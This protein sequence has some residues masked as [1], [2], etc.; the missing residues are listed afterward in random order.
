MQSCLRHGARTVVVQ[1]TIPAF[2]FSADRPTAGGDERH[3]VDAVK[4]EP[5]PPTAEELV[6]TLHDE[7]GAP[8]DVGMISVQRLTFPEAFVRQSGLAP[9]Q[10]VVQWA[11]HEQ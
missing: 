1:G 6:L 10:W 7:R 3:V 11:S 8:L 4:L 2:D 5:A 9:T